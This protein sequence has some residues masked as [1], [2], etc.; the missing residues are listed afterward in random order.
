LDKIKVAHIITQ[1]ELGGAQENT[2]YTITH[3][4]PQFYDCYLIVGKG[5]RLDD[6]ASKSLGSKVFFVPSLVRSIHPWKDLLAWIAIYRTCRREKFDLVHTHSSKAGILGRWAAKVAGVKKIV[7]TYHG[8]GFN[9]FQQP[10]IKGIF[11]L[12]ERIT[13]PITDKIIVVSSE[14][15]VKALAHK[16]G[17]PGQ[18]IVIHSGIKVTVYRDLKI[19]KAG[20]KKK[21]G[22]PEQSP[23]I[24]M[25]A[26][27]KPQKAPLDFVRI[28]RLV[29][30]KIP[31]VKFIMIGDGELRP[32]IEGLIA[33][34]SLSE[35]IKLLGWRNDIPA[36][37]RLMDVC[38]LTSLWE[39][40]PRVILEAFVSGVPVVATPADGTREVV[41]DGQTGFLAGFHDLS[42]FAERIKDLLENPE[43]TRGLL[44][45]PASLL[46]VVLILILWSGI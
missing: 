39:G 36:M 12:I 7:H 13:A 4:D 2:L 40:L 10:W 38:V 27:F 8:F 18:Y 9:D 22:L 1:L 16:I 20:E 45:M 17:K 23:V 33:E 37:I 43:K 5:G 30:D 29:K 26:C 11:V 24:G 31:Q 21:L 35:T 3:L 19:D 44:K 42:A 46:A 25:I 15:T 28:A 32:E 14:N 6:T 41:I 34:L